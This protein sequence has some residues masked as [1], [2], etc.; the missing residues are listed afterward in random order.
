MKVAGSE[1]AVAVG[2]APEVRRHRKLPKISGHA[3]PEVLWQIAPGDVPG[4]ICEADGWSDP[5]RK[6]LSVAALVPGP[7][8]ADRHRPIVHDRIEDDPANDLTSAKH[9]GHHAEQGQ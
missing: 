8:S 7:L 9:G 6:L 5:K 4:Q 1:E 3:R 2:G